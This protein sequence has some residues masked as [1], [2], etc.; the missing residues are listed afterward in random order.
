MFQAI[1]CGRL[2]NTFSGI[3]ID[4][5]YPASATDAANF[6]LLLQAVRAE[7]DAYAAQYAPGYHFLL[8]VASPAGPSNYNVQNLGAMAAVIDF[9]NF[10][11]YDYAGSW[12]TVAGHQANI[13]SNPQNP[14][15]TPFST[16]AAVSDYLTAGVAAHQI[17]LGMPIY[18]RAFES[19]DGPGKP[20]NGIGQGSWEAGI[21]DYKVLPR[22]GATEFTD[23]VAGATYSYDAAA[24]EMVSYDTPAMVATKMGYVKNRGLGGG[25]FW[26]AS[27]DRT[28]NGSLISA[29]Y[30]ALGGI[31][32]TQN[33]LSYPNSQYA[34]MAAGM[35]N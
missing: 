6:V 31:D 32:A 11:G 9:F 24:R 19:T 16:D 35:P 34:N 29:S 1:E 18:G 5:E 12:D 22:A 15:A 20:Y 13:Y 3:D 10:M 14:S 21:W 2:P 33:L 27:A 17:V 8:T 26:E 7:L 25:M 4:W 23:S 30:Q 28:N